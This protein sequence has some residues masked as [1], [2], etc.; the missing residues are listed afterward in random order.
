MSASDTIHALLG[1]AKRLMRLS[2]PREDGPDAVLVVNELIAN[3]AVSRDFEFVVTAL[4]DDAEIALKDVQCKLVSIELM[5]SDQSKRYFT[6]Y[7]FEFRLVEYDNSLAV[8]QMILRPWLTFFKL[9]YDHFIF[10]N[11]SIE[12]Q[13]K[14]IFCDSGL[15]S[16][17]FRTREPD[18]VRTFS[19]QYDESDYNYLHRRWEEMGWHYWYEHT[20]RGH[21]L[22]LSDASANADP[23][24]GKPLIPYHHDGGSNKD[25]KISDWSPVRQVVSGKVAFSN[26]D[27]KTPTP[28]KLSETSELKQGD[29]HKIEVYQYQGLYG[30]KD[31]GQ[32]A[33]IAKRHMEQIEAEGKF[34]EARGDCRFVQSGRWF[35]L[36]KEHDSLLFPGSASDHEFFILTARHEINNNFLNSA[37]SEATYRNSFSCLRRIIPWRPAIGFNSELTRIPGVDTATVTGPA[38]EEIHTDKYGRIKVQFHWD[39]EGSNDEKSSAWIRVM[40]P[41]AD[42]NFGMISLPRIGTEVVIQYLQ[43]NPDR[44]LVVGQLYNERH[45]PPWDLPAHKTQSGILSRSSKG[46]SAANAN[47]FRFEDEKG[48]EEV[49]LHAEKD[50]RIE[51]EN[52]ESHWVGHDRTKTIDHDETVHVK[53]DRT[54]TVDHDETITVHNDRTETVDHNEKIT[55]HNDRTERVDH[56]ESISIGDNRT[57]DVGKNESITIGDNRSKTVGQNETDK[58]GDN[59]SINVGQMKTETIGM[60]NT[61]SIGMFK[62]VNIGAAYNLNVGAAMMTNV[63]LGR[64]DTVAMAWSQNTGTKHNHT[65]GNEYTLIVGD[66]SLTMKADGTIILKGKDIQLIG[67]GDINLKASG[68][69]KLKASQIDDN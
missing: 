18:P 57:E 54:E 53:H 31:A 33:K 8:Y 27:F 47:A 6:G 60:G 42:K 32:G 11:K 21:K 45:L 10:H 56:N 12:V 50:Q 20:E 38:G 55:V 40:T 62:M 25:D 3:E 22:I 14:E 48:K 51:V 16:Y 44:P 43:G 24:D 17:D 63:G 30:Y 28:Q 46:G 26:Y 13:T 23:I 68:N 34:F 69:M 64:M 1:S 37:G 49:W 7:C 67:S 66:A 15:S 4:S 9:R 52:D 29:I 2:F 65:V 61:Q 39:R 36:T 58:I 41:W 59:W 35:R 19:M 5:R